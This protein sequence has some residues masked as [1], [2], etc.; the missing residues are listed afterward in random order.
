[1]LRSWRYLFVL[2]FVSISFLE[3]KYIRL[4]NLE[5]QSL[6]CIIE[7]YADG[8]LKTRLK[9]GRFF[10][11]PVEQLNRS[12]IKKA[13]AEIRTNYPPSLR[14][15]SLNVSRKKRTKVNRKGTKKV[16]IDKERAF[17]IEV[18]TFCPIRTEA[19]VEWYFISEDTIKSH[20]SR[21][22]T[23][24]PQKEAQF[25]ISGNTEWLGVQYK[26]GYIGNRLDSS[27]GSQKLDL[28]VILKN[29]NGAVEKT[30]STSKRAESRVK[31]MIM[32]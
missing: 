4:T 7:G 5:G 26:S 27:K 30:Y 2:Y 8:N 3:A 16:Q 15:R 19:T 21:K 10:S 1:M 13:Y 9:N 24:N 25:E 22:V 14:V 17:Q 29:I 31:E 18:S 32:R 20:N 6:E 11:L 28:V 12:S 23:L